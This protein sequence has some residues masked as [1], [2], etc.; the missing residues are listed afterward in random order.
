M[1]DQFYSIEKVLTVLSETPQRIAALAEGTSAVQLRTPPK[2]DEWSANEVLAHLRA[3]ADVWGGYIHRILTEDHPKF[4]ALSPRTYI[5]KTNYTEV[6]FQPSLDA[7][8]AQRA[9][10]LAVLEA[11]SPASWQRAA[12]VTNSS[13]KVLE[14]NVIH[15]ANSMASHEWDHIE[16][17]E[18]T[19]NKVRTQQ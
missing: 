14:N 8:T 6:E 18:D 11:L 1:S 5:R 9:E 10:L 17:I 15:Y 7:F 2:P 4:R 13:G 16:Q 19:L 12:T 3:C